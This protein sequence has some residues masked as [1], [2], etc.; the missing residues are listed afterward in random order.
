MTTSEVWLTIGDHD[1]A[2]HYIVRGVVS[3]EPGGWETEKLKHVGWK[4][5]EV[6]HKPSLV[7]RINVYIRDMTCSAEGILEAKK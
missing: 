7:A 2:N 6:A 3:A 4:I 1:Q 5:L